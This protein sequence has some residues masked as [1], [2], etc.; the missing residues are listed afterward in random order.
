MAMALRRLLQRQ[1]G[2]CQA[3]VP[4]C[5]LQKQAAFLQSHSWQQTRSAVAV[6]QKTTGKG[7]RDDMLTKKVSKSGEA[8]AMFDTRVTLS[9]KLNS[10]PWIPEDVKAKM[11]ELHRNRITKAGEFTV[12]CEITSNQRE[13]ERL[14]IKMIEDLIKEAEHE[15]KK[16]AFEASKLDHKEYVI[17]KFKKE[18]REKD[19]EKR[20]EAIKDQKRRSREKTRSKKESKYW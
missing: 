16:D 4:C 8:Q 10:V 11:R 1:T 18:G 13:N 19:L 12:R 2:F 15:L 3:A 14:A 9:F 6:P 5:R 17:Q 7:Y 20:E